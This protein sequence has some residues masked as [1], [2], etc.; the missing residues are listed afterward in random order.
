MD[1]TRSFTYVS[2][3]CYTHIIHLRN[4]QAIRSDRK[5]ANRP[6]SEF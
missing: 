2:L 5:Q 6:S 4:L 1:V 3:L